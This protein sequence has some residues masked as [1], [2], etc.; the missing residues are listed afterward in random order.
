MSHSNTN[1]ITSKKSCQ[2]KI[3]ADFSPVNHVLQT[4]NYPNE[5]NSAHL[6]MINHKSKVIATLDFSSGYYQ[7]PIPEKDR[8]LFAFLLP[9]GKFRFTGLPQGTKPARDIFDIISNEEL[10]EVKQAQ[11]NMDN[12][13]LSETSYKTL[14]PVID[15]VLSICRR[16]NMKINPDKFKVGKLVEFGGTTVR[17]SPANERVQ[18]S[19]S[20]A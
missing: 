5:G 17:Y 16:K 8:D 11:K 9:Q 7:I 19:P 2:P 15:K 1:S 6:K 12:I 4:P 3:K 18:I 14:D 10:R 13:L 20:E